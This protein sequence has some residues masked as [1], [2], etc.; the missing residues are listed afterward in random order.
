MSVILP[1]I[2]P[3]DFL[4]A[5][6]NNVSE[7]VACPVPHEQFF[8]VMTPRGEELRELLDYDFSRLLFA[9]AEYDAYLILVSGARTK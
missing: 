2:P 3:Q 6:W 8:D 5:T 9:A 1:K 4:D 7:K